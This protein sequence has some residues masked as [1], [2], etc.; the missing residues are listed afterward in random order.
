MKISNQRKEELETAYI[1]SWRSL[2]SQNKLG[3]KMR[4]EIR[5]AEMFKSLYLTRKDRKTGELKEIPV[6]SAEGQRRIK[7]AQSAFNIMASS[8]LKGREAKAFKLRANRLNLS[9]SLD[10]KIKKAV[11]LDRESLIRAHQ[12]FEAKEWYERMLEQAEENGLQEGETANE[13][14]S[15]DHAN[16]KSQLLETDEW[17]DM[18]AEAVELIIA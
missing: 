6:W 16:I 10:D 12:S 14:V 3:R 4:S 9:L 15:R 1:K 7:R 5:T 8:T 13:A 18:A 2:I 17:A 11:G